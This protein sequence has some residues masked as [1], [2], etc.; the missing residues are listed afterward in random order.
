MPRSS[1]KKIMACPVHRQVKDECEE[2]IKLVNSF[3]FSAVL[4]TLGLQQME[5]SIDWLRIREWLDS[6]GYTLIPVAKAFFTTPSRRRAAMSEADKVKFVTIGGGK[7]AAGYANPTV[8]GGALAILWGNQKI[9]IRNGT[10]KAAI[11][12]NSD[13]ADE[14]TVANPKLS[15]TRRLRAL[16]S[17]GGRHTPHL[18]A[19]PEDDEDDNAA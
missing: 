15:T 12:F 7:K 16:K 4:K 17:E 19:P 9:R 18:L 3:E 5:D 2:R 6:E 8:E 10:Q 1:L 13:A 11:K 14:N